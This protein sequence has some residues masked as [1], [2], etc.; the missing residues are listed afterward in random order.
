MESKV[1]SFK[2][3]CIYL[4]ICFFNM[5][6]FQELVLDHK[7]KKKYVENGICR[8]GFD[9]RLNKILLLDFISS[10]NIKNDVAV[11]KP[12]FY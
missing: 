5:N 1:T 10:T 9:E 4:N 7:V 2:W 11:L 12:D 6:P 3:D 8:Y